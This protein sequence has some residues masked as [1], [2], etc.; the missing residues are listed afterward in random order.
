MQ[1]LETKAHAEALFAKSENVQNHLRVAVL[2]ADDPEWAGIA[3]FSAGER[4]MKCLFLLGYIEH[5]TM[6]GYVATPEGVAA[7]KAFKEKE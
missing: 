7:Y 2:A 5:R 4:V 1:P 6:R 3:A